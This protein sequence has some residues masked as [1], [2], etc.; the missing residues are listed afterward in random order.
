[1]SVCLCMCV[2]V[3]MRVRVCACQYIQITY[4]FGSVLRG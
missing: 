1:M 3:C 2:C 4:E